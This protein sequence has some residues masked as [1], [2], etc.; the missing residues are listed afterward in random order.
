MLN[1]I[2]RDK[3]YCGTIVE[4]KT[5][6]PL[7]KCD[8]V[9][10][11][12]IFGNSVIV[13]KDTKPG[14]IG[15]FFPAETELSAGFLCQNS[16]YRDATLNANPEKKGYFEKHGRIKTMSF[17]SFKSEGFF[18]PINSLNYL[19]TTLN[20]SNM[21][22]EEFNE[23]NG[24]E[25]C[26]KYI[27]K[28]DK[29]KGPAGTKKNKESVKV[30]KLVPEQFRLHYDTE[31]LRKNMDKINPEDLISI[32]D[33]WHGTSFVVA[34]VLTIQPMNWFHR[35]LNKYFKV[36]I[37]LTKYDNIYSSRKVIKNGFINSNPNH[38]YGYDLWKDISDIIF[39]LLPQGFSVYGE[40]A[41]FLPS[42][43]PIQKGY[44]YSCKP[45]TFKCLIYRATFTS[46]DGKV[47]E[48][49][50]PM[51]KEF[52]AARGLEMVKE[53]YYGP[54]KDVF[55]TIKLL[56]K[57]EAR[58]WNDEGP[59]SFGDRVIGCGNLRDWQDEF[60]VALTECKAYN[61]GDVMCKDNNYEVPAEGI[62]LRKDALS[63]SVSFKL[64]NFKFNCYET[65]QLDQGLIDL[66][67]QESVWEEE[68][69]NG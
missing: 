33:K 64:K 40:A 46:A 56:N 42:G 44:H 48:L 24:V 60:L 1:I 5:L 34:N 28:S 30:S 31:Q 19:H 38:F 61:M 47:F 13:G 18:I 52:C 62:V 6:V 22:N 50:W 53:F 32:S 39:P 59:E 63:Q 43:A 26:K 54:A 65:T 10:A 2:L 45:N 29:V 4:I 27:P 9:V 12:M 16:L 20:F 41:G 11:A 23:I 15:I 69:D 66:E 7:A 55:P 67:S 17:R 8:N 57:E 36:P 35:I 68:I 58:V 3:N 14:D 21:V 51:L 25:L 37:E 49:S